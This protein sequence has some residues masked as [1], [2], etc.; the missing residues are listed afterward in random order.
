MTRRHFLSATAA[1]PALL[2]SQ[3]PNNVIRVGMIGVG[4]RGS[5]LLRQ[6]LKVPNVKVV[7]I[8]DIDP[9]ALERAGEAAGV[10]GADLMTDFRKL[11]DRKDIDAVI[12]ATPVDLH[13]EMAM[14][15]LE[16]G[17]NLYCEKPMGRTPQECRQVLQATKTAKG[18]F[19]A[20]FQ[21]RHDPY[22]AASVNFIHSGGIGKVLFLQAYRHT[23]DLPRKTGWY[24]DASRSGDNIVE[25]ACHIIDIYNWV[26]QTH[27]LRAYGSGGI[28]LYHDQPPGRTTMDNYAVIFEFPNDV[29]FTFS[30]IYF[31]PPNFTGIQER[32][33]CAD[34]AID[35]PKALVYDRAQKGPPRKIPVEGEGEDMNYLSVA[36]FF[37]HARARQMPPLNNADSARISTLTAI[38]GRTSI[39]E[40][41]VVEWREV[42]L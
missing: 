18:I 29:R 7:A 12:I 15:A 3:S 34:A 21:L 35:L 28:N 22:R 37:E 27:P 17:K 2:Q 14:G 30:H 41:R 20:G 32:V 26:M 11:L 1:V 36:S 23:G 40:K 6:V 25:Q 4:N 8:C 19:Q 39:Y 13:K 10:H 5:F 31:D 38:L 9:A 24:F 42:D 16:V 33:F